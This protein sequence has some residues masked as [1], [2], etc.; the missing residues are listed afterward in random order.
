MSVYRWTCDVSSMSEV[1][2]HLL[3]N[4][5]HMLTGSVVERTINPNQLSGVVESPELLRGDGC[6]H[7]REPYPRR[8]NRCPRSCY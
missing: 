6:T 5:F 1:R 2:I 4:A 8:V 3:R 7:H